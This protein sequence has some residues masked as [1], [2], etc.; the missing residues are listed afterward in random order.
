MSFRIRTFIYSMLI[1]IGTVGIVFAI[2]QT[3]VN[4]QFLQLESQ[5]IRQGAQRAQEAINKELDTLNQIT[6]NW[7][8]RNDTYRFIRDFDP[9]SANSTPPDAELESLDMD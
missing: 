3:M 8:L 4:K 1:V 6:E 5:D 9:R 2:T 7:A